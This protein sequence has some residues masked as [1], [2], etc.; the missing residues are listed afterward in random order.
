[1]NTH[2][3]DTS[4]AMAWYLDES[5]STRAREWQQ[6]L[7]AGKVVMVVPSLHYLEFANVLRTLVRRRE[8]RHELAREVYELHLEAP[9]ERAEPDEKGLLDLALAYEATAY[10][11]V[12]IS[13]CLAR[14]ISLITA[15]K[16][17][18]GWVAKLGGRVEPVR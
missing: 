16:T 15:E 2:V 1:M 10:D 13:L 4:V 17:T 11:A 7:L 3:L 12:Y 8:L 14:N 18:T 5:F 6:R 9:L